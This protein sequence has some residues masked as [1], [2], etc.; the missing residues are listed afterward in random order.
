V[1]ATAFL[2]LSMLVFGAWG[3]CHRESEMNSFTARWDEMKASPSPDV[4]AERLDA[5][6]AFARG[7]GLKYRV[8]L[9]DRATGQPVPIAAIAAPS[10]HPVRVRVVIDGDTKRTPLEWE[11]RDVTNVTRLLRE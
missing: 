6:V 7:R 3:S 5:L 11:P 10:T 8:T 9:V 1:K 2:L 4:E